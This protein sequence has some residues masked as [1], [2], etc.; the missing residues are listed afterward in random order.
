[1]L[2]E[3]HRVLKDSGI[4]IPQCKMFTALLGRAIVLTTEKA[5]LTRSIDKSRQW[6]VGTVI[7][8]NQGGIDSFVLQLFPVQPKQEGNEIVFNEE[9][10]AD[11]E[12]KHKKP[13]LATK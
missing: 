1:L 11:G 6:K 4:D 3:W 13:K 7:V 8:I 12:P 5:L 9:G 2:K 10:D